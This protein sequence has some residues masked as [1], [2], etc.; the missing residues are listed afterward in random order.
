MIKIAV[1]NHTDLPIE[2]I[3][4]VIDYYT[5]YTDEEETFYF[6]K[7]DSIKFRMYE[8]DYKVTI[9]YMKKEIQYIIEEDNNGQRTKE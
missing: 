3:G 1:M 4:K 6:G 2:L 9:R 7:T 8:K 5:N